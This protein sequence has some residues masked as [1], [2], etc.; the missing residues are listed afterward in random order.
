MLTV[1]LLCATLASLGVA[2]RT[3]RAIRGLPPKD[4]QVTDDSSAWAAG[5]VLVMSVG[6][7]LA[8]LTVAFR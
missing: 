4:L 2:A 5:A 6:G 1:G 8:C 3:I 7:A